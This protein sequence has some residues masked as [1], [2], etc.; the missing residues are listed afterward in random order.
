MS[1]LGPHSGKKK[2]E[3]KENKSVKQDTKTTKEG[4]MGEKKKSVKWKH[5]N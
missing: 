4:K 1:L 3:L 5:S 2:A